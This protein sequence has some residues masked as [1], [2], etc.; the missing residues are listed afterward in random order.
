[1]AK[2]DGL[3]FIDPNATDPMF[4][5]ARWDELV[6][7]EPKNVLKGCTLPCPI[8]STTWQDKY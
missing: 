7:W 1:M 2:T 4:R 3:W 5:G 8:S 6:V